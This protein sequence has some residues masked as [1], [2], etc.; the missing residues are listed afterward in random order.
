MNMQNLTTQTYA[1]TV[2]AQFEKSVSHY[3]KI[4]QRFADNIKGNRYKTQVVNDSLLN[5][6]IN[7]PDK[8]WED[9]NF[10]KTHTSSL[11]LIDIDITLQR[12]LIVT[13]CADIINKFKQ[14][15]VMPICVYE[16]ANNPGRY[17]CWDGQHTAVVL[18]LIATQVYGK[19]LEEINVPIVVYDSSQKSEM[20]E[21][22]ITLNGEGKTPLDHIDIFQQMVFGVRTDGSKNPEWVLAEKKQQALENNFMFATH[23]KFGDSHEPGAYSRLNELIDKNYTLTITENFAKYFFKVCGSSRPVE[24]K[25]SWMLYAFFDACQKQRIKVDDQ[26]I[27]GVAA[28]LRK[29]FKNDFDALRMYSHAV[30]CYEEWWRVNK[31]NPDGSLLGITRNERKIG[32]EFL[33]AQIGKNF[34]GKLPVWYNSGWTVSKKDLF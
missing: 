8:K 7:N 19:T 15:M 34:T 22:F 23:D 10:C 13:H 29:A 28:S 26:Y 14:L 32:M 20:R 24:P 3:V 5:F 1:D 30:T 2:N 25:E 17:V 12:F 18:Y 11:A 4:D 21:S 16:D 31:P 33:I 6:K 9:F 27:A